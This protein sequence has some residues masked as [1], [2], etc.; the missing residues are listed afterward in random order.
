[1]TLIKNNKVG[2]DALRGDY[3]L[4]IVTETLIVW[5]EPNGTDMALSFQEAEGCS[6]IWSVSIFKIST[7]RADDDPRDFL[8]QVQ[9]QLM[10]MAGP[11]NCLSW[12]NPI[13]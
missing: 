5:T 9:Q 1:M 7:R 8:S 13:C 6:A 2:V 4:R 12:S 10:A 11:G 3:W